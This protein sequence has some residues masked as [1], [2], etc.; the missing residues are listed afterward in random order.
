LGGCLAM[1]TSCIDSFGL[2]TVETVFDGRIDASVIEDTERLGI[3]LANDR[4]RKCGKCG[5][6]CTRP[7][8]VR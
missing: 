8:Q 1:L 6:K 7:T 4:F 2:W 3:R 5:R